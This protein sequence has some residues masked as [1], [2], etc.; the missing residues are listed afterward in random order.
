MSAGLARFPS[1]VSA[2]D[3]HPR[4]PEALKPEIR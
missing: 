2:K 4:K 1:P 3:D